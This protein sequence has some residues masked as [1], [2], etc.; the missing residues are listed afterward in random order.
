LNHA[1]PGRDGQGLLRQLS[2]DLGKP[3]LHLLGELEQAR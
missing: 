1:P 3:P 2:L